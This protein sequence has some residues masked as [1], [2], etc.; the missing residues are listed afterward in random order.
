LSLD[1]YS[2]ITESSRHV[3]ESLQNT[4][5][6]NICV[7]VLECFWRDCGHEQSFHAFMELQRH[8]Y[9]HAFHTRLKSIGASLSSKNALPMCQFDSS[10]RNSLPELPDQLRCSWH[11]C[12]VYL[13]IFFF[14][15]KHNDR[16]VCDAF[17]FIHY[18]NCLL[19][20][21]K[22]LCLIN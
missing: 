10:N 13:C 12:E 1:K 15:E 18:A 22:V 14:F 8:V 16:L 3:H 20:R 5:L 19:F 6:D 17:I 21:K 4:V 9:F 2:C 11:G 7:A